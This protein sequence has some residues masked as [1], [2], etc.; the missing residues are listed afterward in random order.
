MKYLH[1][2][3]R[4]TNLE[5]TLHFYCNIL[6]LIEISR[7][8]YPQ[9]KFTLIFLVA[10]EDTNNLQPPLIEIT[11]NWDKEEYTGG[12]NFGHLAFRVKNIYE[13]CEKFIDAGITINF[14]PRNGYMAFVRSPDN[15]SIELLQED[16]A[17]EVKEP[18][19]SMPTIGEW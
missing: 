5:E 13:T 9:E 10:D 17:L 6:G 1:T 7:K 4:A 8:D 15:I 18:W 12:R 2:M 11:Y 14:P 3:I 19:S 16:R